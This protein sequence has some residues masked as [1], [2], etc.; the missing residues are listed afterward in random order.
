MNISD[1]I[2]WGQM[3]HPSIPTPFPLSRAPYQSSAF[4]IHYLSLGRMLQMYVA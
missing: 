4:E 2:I 1:P 3:D